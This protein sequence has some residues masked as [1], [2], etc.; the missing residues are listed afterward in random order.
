MEMQSWK[1]YMFQF[2]NFLQSYSNEENVAL[3]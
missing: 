2:Q 3:V 1:A